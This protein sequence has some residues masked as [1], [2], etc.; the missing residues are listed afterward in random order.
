M[1]MLIWSLGYYTG[2]VTGTSLGPAGSGRLAAGRFPRS[3]LTFPLTIRSR[4]GSV[5]AR[6][7][8]VRTRRVRTTLF[9]KHLHL[10]RA[11]DHYLI[12]HRDE[13]PAA[14]VAIKEGDLTG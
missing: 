12:T 8:L 5:E 10:L 3:P 6:C 11:A 13:V 4:A 9:T 2:G 14:R 7:R 1:R